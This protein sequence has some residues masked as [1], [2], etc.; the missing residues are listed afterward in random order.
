MMPDLIETTTKHV[1]EL[2]LNRPDARN[3]LSNS[4][5][6]DLRAAL[7]EAESDDHIRSIVITGSG[8]AFSAGVDLAELK[9]MRTASL[10]ENRRSSTGLANLFRDIRIHPK[11]VIAKVN[12][13][14]IAGGCGLA[15]ACDL[16]IVSKRAKLGF[17]EVRIGFVPAIVSQLLRGRVQD[18]ILRD[19]LLTGRLVD[20]DEAVGCGL[21][22]K[23]VD[24]DELADAVLEVTDTIEGKTSPTAVALTKRMLVAT[25]GMSPAFSATFLASYN[26]L[27][28]Q[29]DDV[30]I[31]VSAFLEKKEPDWQ[32]M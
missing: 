30:E 14:A 23:V 7:S 16:S 3:A 2:T 18:V 15:V 21:V 17:P 24:P 28:R 12:G 9:A 11:P 27:A 4:L 20:A 8:N 19:L 5:I 32:Q 29:T 6:R 26:A 31:G 10:A 1:R 13:H 22:T 25:E